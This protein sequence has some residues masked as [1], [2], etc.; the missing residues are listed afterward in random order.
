MLSLADVERARVATRPFVRHTPLEY[1]P[2]L[3]RLSGAR[4]YLKLENLQVTGAFKPRGPF[5][6]LQALT[7]EEKTRGVVAATA[8]NHGVGL[9]CAGQRLGIPV[10]VH[11]PASADPG[12][13]EKLGY[14]GATLHFAKSFEA[15]HWNALRMADADGLVV[16]S[17]YNDEWVVASD[18]VIGLEILDDLPEVDTIVVPVGG[19]GLAGGIG[20]AIKSRHPAVALWGVEAAQSPSFN[21]WMKNGVPGPVR[22]EDSIA[23]GLAGFIEPETITWPLVRAYVNRMLT[24]TEE[25]LIEAMR[26]MVTKHGLIIEASGA[27]AIAA[28]LKE[29]ETLRGRRVAVLISGG[30]ISW[31]RFVALLKAPA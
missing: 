25:E 19:G 15:A 30:N 20:M 29:P 11:I 10:H 12:K 24:A 8:G 22:L 2:D 21:T 16:V 27:A 17:A 3:S 26:W 5:N 6:R 31:E 23:E 18:G 28:V 9:S 13:L 4:V 1:S 7:P 14:Y